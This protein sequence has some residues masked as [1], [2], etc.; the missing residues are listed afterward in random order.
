MNLE[1]VLST[2]GVKFHLAI[3]NNRANSLKRIV[4]L[5]L[6]AQHRRHKNPTVSSH[7]DEG[8]DDISLRVKLAL[9]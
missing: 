1:N 4:S 8:S 2:M 3:T 5:V 7:S 9:N 6:H